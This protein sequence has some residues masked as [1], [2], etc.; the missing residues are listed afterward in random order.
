MMMLPSK[1]KLPPPNARCEEISMFA[2][3]LPCGAP[4]KF[5]VKNRD[6][7]PYNMCAMCADHNVSNRGARYVTEDE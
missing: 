3:P 4:A 2:A 5:I 6:P 7:R 1:R